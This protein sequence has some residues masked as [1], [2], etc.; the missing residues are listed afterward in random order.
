MTYFICDIHDEHLD[1]VVFP[2]FECEVDVE[3]IVSGGN[4]DTIIN[5]VTVDGRSLNKGDEVSR[6]LAA[7]VA[8]L[9]ENELSQGGLFW[10]RVREEHGVE[11]VG[12][13]G[14]DPDGRWRKVA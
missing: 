8:N 4:I 9:A 13:G 6:A 11:Y 7:R 12:F 3:V 2:D 10:E 14:N 1:R 5:D